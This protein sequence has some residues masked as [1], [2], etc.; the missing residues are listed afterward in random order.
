[1]V[2]ATIPPSARPPS[3]H[4]ADAAHPA[5]LWWVLARRGGAAIALGLF[6]LLW[7]VMTVL[8]LTL[9]FAAY[10]LV[11]GVFSIVLAVRGVRHGKRW[12]MAALHGAVALVAAA[13]VILFPTITLMIFVALL[14]AWALVN[15][16]LAVIA[17]LRPARKPRW[18]ARGGSAGASARSR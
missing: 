3:A 17:A 10:N 14:I 11:E 15:G 2:S 12:G 18:M 9:L 1:M 7:P 6:A 13:V 16:L 4:E 8:T 5:G